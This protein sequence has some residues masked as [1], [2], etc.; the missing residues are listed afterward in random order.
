LT[1]WRIIAEI[2]GDE[3]SQHIGGI[4]VVGY[5]A[6][7]PLPKT[8]FFFLVDNISVSAAKTD[9]LRNQRHIPSCDQMAVTGIFISGRSS[10]SKYI[11]QQ[12]CIQ[13]RRRSTSA[14][15]ISCVA[16]LAWKRKEQHRANLR[17]V[18]SDIFIDGPDLRTSKSGRASFICIFHACRHIYNCPLHQRRQ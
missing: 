5:V 7:V 11:F 4:V 16:R 2:F 1:P 9:F 14:S 13:E 8:F 6:I 17:R 15:E 10:D 18:F 12:L 3:I